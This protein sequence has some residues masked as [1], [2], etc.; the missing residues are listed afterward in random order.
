MLCDDPALVNKKVDKTMI[1]D[2]QDKV[3]ASEK[4]YTKE[5]IISYEI[6]SRDSRIGEITNCASSILNKYAKN[7]KV[8]QQNAD[9][10]SLLRILQ[11]EFL[12][13]LY[14]NI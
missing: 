12:A 5:N 4:E 3:T 9:D 13:P 1:I 6:N 14:S 7:D 8:K 10:V 2:I 11:G